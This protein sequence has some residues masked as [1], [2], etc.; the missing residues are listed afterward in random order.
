MPGVD[1]ERL[2]FWEELAG[3]GYE[4]LAHII[5]RFSRAPEWLDRERLKTTLI[6]LDPEDLP[7]GLVI[8]DIVEGVAAS[9]YICWLEYRRAQEPA[10]PSIELKALHKALSRWVDK[11]I[12]GREGW[13]L[14]RRDDGDDKRDAIAGLL[15]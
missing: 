14:L 3:V 4:P 6:A 5:D 13:L 8:D 15:R 7:I 2:V 10:G 9:L 11:H 12:D 1:Y